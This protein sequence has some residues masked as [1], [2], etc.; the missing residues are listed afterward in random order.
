MRNWT[1]K[2]QVALFICV[3]L[4]VLGLNIFA[5]VTNNQ[6][7]LQWTKPLFVPVI[8]S[9]YLYRKKKQD[10]L[11]VIFLLFFFLG[12]YLSAISKD[13][14]AIRSSNV[15]HCLSYLGLLMV[16]ARKVKRL[17]IDKVVGGYLLV[18][19]LINAYFL[20]VL[21]EILKVTVVDDF[22]LVLFIISGTV[23][24]VMLFVSF[25]IY[26]SSDTK[27]AIMFLMMGLC[28]VFAE[29]FYFVGEYYLYHWSFIA[30]NRILYVSG[31]VFLILYRDIYQSV[32]VIKQLDEVNT[33][34]RVVF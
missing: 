26:L 2:S 34:E 7:L 30:F 5:S 20:L 25:A 27:Q 9:F 13:I 16:L 19:F 11:L 24:F 3:L 6:L 1:T 33:V 23:L 18:V 8:L 21:F 28:F 31:L 12:D 4:C 29:V 17:S 14:W 15:L 10:T 22:K 32:K